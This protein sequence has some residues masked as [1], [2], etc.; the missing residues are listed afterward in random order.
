MVFNNTFSHKSLSSNSAI[1]CFSGTSA[2]TNGKF[3]CTNAGF[4][5][6]NIPSSRVN[7][8]ICGMLLFFCLLTC[9][10]VS[11]V[12]TFNLIMLSHENNEC[13]G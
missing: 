6:L 12:P 8:E 7:D 9:T 5:P 1:P 4:K 3:H 2:C 10:S 11:V 13:K